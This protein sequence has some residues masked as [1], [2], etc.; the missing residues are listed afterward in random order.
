MEY[1]L[2]ISLHQG[3]DGFHQR[4][5]S[6]TDIVSAQFNLFFYMASGLEKIC[7][8]IPGDKVTCNKFDTL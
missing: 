5:G 1:N 8:S 6:E 7:M 2:V 3:M 4:T